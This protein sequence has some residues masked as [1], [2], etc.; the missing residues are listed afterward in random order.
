MV[1]KTLR[2]FKLEGET[3]SLEVRVHRRSR[4]RG[5][6]FYS[7]ELILGPGDRIVVDAPSAPLSERRMRLIAPA[8]IYCRKKLDG[9]ENK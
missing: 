4:N 9:M 6:P 8:G 2:I 1:E 7:S 5:A 3:G